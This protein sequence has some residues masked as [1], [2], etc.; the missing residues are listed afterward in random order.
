MSLFLSRHLAI[1]CLRQHGPCTGV[2]V[3]TGATHTIPPMRRSQIPNKHWNPLFRKERAAKFLKIE[4]VDHEWDRKRARDE[5]T[6]EEVKEKL[7]KM[8]IKPASQYNEKPLYI[9]STG[10]LLD[11]Y[12]PPEGDGKASLIS[13]AG[14]K[15]VGEKVKG[16]GKTMS[17]I[18][19]FRS[20]DEDFDPRE[21]VDEALEIYIAAHRALADGEHELM[22]KF[23]TEKAYPEMMNMA[24]R[25][26]IRWNFIKSLEPPRVLHARHAEILSKENM[27]G[28]LT[29]RM[30]TQQTL[31]VYDRFG[32]LIHGSETVAKD[33][34]E[35]VVF[36]K[37]LA[38]IYGTWRLH[39]KI[40]PDWMP[41]R[42]P[43]H[44]TY[45]VPSEAPPKDAIEKSTGQKDDKEEDGEKESI[46][47]RFG[48][49][50]GR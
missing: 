9:S 12:V 32:R 15:Q 38:N 14:A 17:S 16:K 48:R 30:N 49:I 39:A 29:V 26:T 24:K 11:A 27:F 19:K 37:H 45:R 22:H 6:P 5:I 23:A 36:E 10:A 40:I 20:Y 47:D 13:T 41:K 3:R 43:G 4:L 21:W 44:L 34:L 46:Y 18:R 33:V 50:L 8:G 25:K 35:Y 2:P 28:Q 31:A 7:K 1:P 42:E